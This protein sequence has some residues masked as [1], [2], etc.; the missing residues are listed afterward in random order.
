MIDAFTRRVREFRPWVAPLGVLKV[1]CVRA[2][3]R[4][5]ANPTSPHILPPRHGATRPLGRHRKA[6]RHRGERAPTPAPP[7]VFSP[8]RTPA[9]PPPLPLARAPSALRLH[10]FLNPLVSVGGE[11]GRVLGWASERA[12]VNERSERAGVNERSE[13]ARVNE[14]SERPAGVNER[15]ERAGVSERSKG[16]VNE[17]SGCAERALVGGGVGGDES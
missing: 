17:R 15:S 8:K 5:T 10:A 14:R 6:P 1:V 13:R 11:S 4:E 9:P 7:T 12:R 3:V 16:R 2:C